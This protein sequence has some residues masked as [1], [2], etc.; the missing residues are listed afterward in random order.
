MN[1]S[2][3]AYGWFLSRVHVK[4]TKKS[5]CYTVNA[6]KWLS[7]KEGEGGTFREFK[8]QERVG[9]HDG[10]LNFFTNAIYQL[11]ILVNSYC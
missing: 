2:F 6:E 1:S 5:I 10:M 8:V 3:S 9:Y 7:G 11:V 4:D